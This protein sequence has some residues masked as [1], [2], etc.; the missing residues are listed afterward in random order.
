MSMKSFIEKLN[1]KKDIKIVESLSG[2][3]SW[4]DEGN[5]MV[6]PTPLEIWS[7]I[8]LIPA[9][10]VA[11]IDSIRNFL[12]HKHSTDIACPLTTG[13][14]L[15]ICANASEEYKLLGKEKKII[16]WWRTIKNNGDLNPKYPNSF[17]LQSELLE[18]ENWKINYSKKTP[19]LVDFE[20]RIF[21]FN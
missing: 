4:A 11:N 10:K 9:F 2:N 19:R 7:I 3:I 15:N 13:I 5:S 20:N 17:R 18:K 6:V 21:K 12:S 14:F 1:N 16:P 8:K